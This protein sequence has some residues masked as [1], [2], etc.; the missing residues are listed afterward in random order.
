MKNEKSKAAQSALEIKRELKHVYPNTK[1]KVRSQ[2]FG[3]E[4]AVR[5]SWYDG[6]TIPQVERITGAYQ[7]G[8]FDHSKNVYKIS[9]VNENIPQV[10]YITTCRMMTNETEDIIVEILQKKYPED[11][12]G[13]NRDGFVKKLNAS[14]RQ[15]IWREFFDMDLYNR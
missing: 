13:K 7:Y 6:P 11:C 12:K 1:F 3:K 4:D 8:Y 15:L 9:N 5:V 10:R 14:M 2:T